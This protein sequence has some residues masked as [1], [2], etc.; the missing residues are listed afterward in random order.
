MHINRPIEKGECVSYPGPRDVWK[1]LRRRSKI[2]STPEWVNLKRTIQKFSRQRC[3]RE[4]NVSP[5]T[6]VALDGPAHQNLFSAAAASPQTMLE[7]LTMSHSLSF[8]L[9]GIDATAVK[10]RQ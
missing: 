8:F 3:P 5:R 7:E 10:E 1:T 6:A 4:E 9:R 2:Q